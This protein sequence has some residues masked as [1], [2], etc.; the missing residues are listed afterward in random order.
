MAVRSALPR[1]GMPSRVLVWLVIALHFLALLQFVSL[2]R[3]RVYV[4]SKRTGDGCVT[5]SA[6]AYTKLIRYSNN[7]V[8]LESPMASGCSVK[9]MEAG[10][11]VC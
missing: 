3:T 5:A 2:S 11:N 1:T 4:S 9:A 8:V 7:G 10:C 6:L